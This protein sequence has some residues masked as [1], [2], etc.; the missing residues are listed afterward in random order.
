MNPQLFLPSFLVLILLSTCGTTTEIT[1]NLTNGSNVSENQTNITPALNVSEADLALW[2]NI[3]RRNVEAACLDAAREEAGSEAWGVYD[4][5]CIENANETVKF[6]D[7]T[8]N[9]VDSTTDYFA[10]IN[11]ALADKYCVVETNY[12]TQNVTFEELKEKY[13]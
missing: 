8:V 13:D 10:R 3:T 12:G 2:G 5:L 7:C 4:C 1:E 9:T 11:C 6:Y